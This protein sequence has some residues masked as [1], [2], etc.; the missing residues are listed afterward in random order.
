MNEVGLVLEKE[1]MINGVIMTQIVNDINIIDTIII[2]IILAIFTKNDM[3]VIVTI[4]IV[5]LENLGIMT[6]KT[7]MKNAEN[8][9]AKTRGLTKETE[10]KRRRITSGEKDEKEK[11]IFIEIE[12]INAN[13]T[14]G[15]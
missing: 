15:E 14:I 6:K 11:K 13:A 12:M 10:I 9:E 4:I 3:T 1:Q 5:R 2:V 7:T 8:E